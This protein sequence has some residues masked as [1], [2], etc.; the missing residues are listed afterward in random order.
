MIEAVAAAGVGR[1]VYTSAPHA[2][3][4]ALVLAPEHKATE[5]LIQASGL[6]FTI[7]RNG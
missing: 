4:S 5:A 6:A 1:I 7:L 3:T 2:D